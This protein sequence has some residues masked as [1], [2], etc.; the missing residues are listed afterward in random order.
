MRKNFTYDYA[1]VMLMLF[2]VYNLFLK[3]LKIYGVLYQIFM[4]L[5]IIVNAIILIIFRK[6]IKYKA[7][8]VIVYLLIWL[9]SKN[10]LQCFFAFSNIIT[11]CAS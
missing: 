10:V 5:L 8:I 9:F 7:L 2:I 1:L 11:R 4:F 3:S 6:K